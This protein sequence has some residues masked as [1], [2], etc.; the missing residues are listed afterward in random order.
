MRQDPFQP[1]L[2]FRAEVRALQRQGLANWNAVAAL[3]DG[4]LRALARSGEASEAR[5]RRLRGQAR[6]MLAVGVNAAEA[7]LSG[8]ERIFPARTLLDVCAHLMGESALAPYQA[9]EARRS[10]PSTE[11]GRAHV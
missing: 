8:H 1:A 11:I 9:I 3:S 5:L 2:H 4:D 7:A 6:L 10:E